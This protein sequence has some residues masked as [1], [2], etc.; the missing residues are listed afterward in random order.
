MKYLPL[1]IGGFIFASVMALTFSANGEKY[2][3]TFKDKSAFELV[4][5]RVSG[6]HLSRS[7]VPGTARL[8]GV[9]VREAEVLDQ[10]GVVI[11]DTDDSRALEILKGH[12]HV[13]V[14]EDMVIP[15]PQPV[16]QAS[17]GQ[18]G[19]RPPMALERPW[20]L[21]KIEAPKAWQRTRGEGVKVLVLDS[22]IDKDHPEFKGRFLL[23]KSFV[24][25]MPGN[26]YDY[27][28]ESGHGTHTSGTILGEF[29][30]VA[31][32]AQLLAG[33]VCHDGCMMSATIAGI[34][35]GIA[36]GVDVINLSLGGPMATAVYLRALEVAEQQGVVIVAASGNG[37]DRSG[38]CRSSAGHL[39]VGLSNGFVCGSR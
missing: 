33:K 36:E 24:F 32:G 30:G 28:D 8:M 2:I 22:G 13:V 20:G 15:A 21:D 3:V 6:G 9:D 25:P 29:V 11:V 4:Q 39:P 18:V 5:A 34:N 19:G 12:P 16:I 27:F 1:R 26:P 38:I 10:L 23:G 14:E 37:A 17:G 31:P 7:H 35:W